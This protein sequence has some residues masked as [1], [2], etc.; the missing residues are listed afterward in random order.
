M[1]WKLNIKREIKITTALLMVF[2]LIA[3]TERQQ[4][5]VVCNNIV[6]QLDNVHENHFLEESDVMKLLD[7]SGQVVKGKNVH[8]FDL[9]RIEK[10]IL[11]DKHIAGA[12]LFSDLKGN[13]VVNVELRR[14]IARIVQEDAPDAYVA[15]DGT[16]MS[17]SEKY[18]SRVM[19]ISGSVKKFLEDEDLMKSELGRQVMEMIKFIHEDK[20]WKAQVAQLDITR[21]GKVTVYP[22]LTG[23]LV[24]F[25]EPENIEEKFRKLK[26]FYKEILPQ[27][28]WTRY[29][30]VNLEY[31]RQVVAE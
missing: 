26:V 19:L 22:Q 14:P 2:A 7:A 3:F 5:A 18:S 23:Q 21:T 20:F 13:L 17:I 24:E 8:D 15:E 9:K 1:K 30:R 12:E 11:L 25:G 16:V 10:K 4:Q 27:R 6:V 29:E 28:G 31:D